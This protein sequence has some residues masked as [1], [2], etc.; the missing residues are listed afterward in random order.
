MAWPATVITAIH[1]RVIVAGLLNRVYTVIEHAQIQSVFILREPSAVFPVDF[2]LSGFLCM[3]V[4]KIVN[5]HYLTSI[6]LL[7]LALW[8]FLACQV[9]NSD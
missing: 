6:Y 1:H 7:I 4:Y 8:L 5:F 2:M 3:L 9:K